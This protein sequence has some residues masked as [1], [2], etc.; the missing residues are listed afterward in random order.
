[1]LVVLGATAYAQSL[2]FAP[3]LQSPKVLAGEVS[4]DGA[5]LK[6]T[7]FTVR[8]LGTGLYEVRFEQGSFLSTCPVMTVS[9]VDYQSSPPA[10]QVY[11]KQISC[12]RPYEIQLTNGEPVDQT[13]DFIAAGT[14]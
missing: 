9:V 6:G 7:G 10:G 1:M 4:A 8:H 14:Q 2:R 5:I 3:A 13:F 12:G 11:Q